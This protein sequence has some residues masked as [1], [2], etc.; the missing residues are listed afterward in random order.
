VIGKILTFNCTKMRL[1]A[2]L[3]PDPLGELTALPQNWILGVGQ[4]KEG[5]GREKGMERRRG[6]GTGGKGGQRKRKG[7]G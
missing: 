7:K 6:K 3:R 1:A 4:G 5:K 2:E